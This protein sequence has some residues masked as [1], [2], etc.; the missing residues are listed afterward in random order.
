MGRYE[1]VPPTQPA[2]DG[3]SPTGHGAPTPSSRIP[4]RPPQERQLKCGEYDRSGDREMNPSDLAGSLLHEMELRGG[5]GAGAEIKGAVPSWRP[6]EEELHRGFVAPLFR[7]GDRVHLA[8]GTVAHA[9]GG[10]APAKGTGSGATTL[11]GLKGHVG[12]RVDLAVH[13]RPRLAASFVNPP[14][15]PGGRQLG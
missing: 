13:G 1:L 7:N 3:P 15:P 12:E 5:S 14:R 6:A 4:L 9:S 2:P 11:H 8:Q 10:T